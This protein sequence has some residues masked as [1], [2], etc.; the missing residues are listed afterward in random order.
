[1]GPFGR[2]LNENNIMF[3][4]LVR[5]L[6]LVV[7]R[8]GVME[9]LSKPSSNRFPMLVGY[10][11]VFYSSRTRKRQKKSSGYDSDEYESE[12]EMVE[13]DN[14]YDLYIDEDE[15]FNPDFRQMTSFVKSPRFDKILRVGLN[16]TRATADEAFLSSRLRLN[17][18]K[19]LKKSVLVQPGDKLDLVISDED[20]T[21]GKR[22][23]VIDVAEQKRDSY[24]VALRCWRSR[25]KL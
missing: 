5:H 10:L 8:L 24:R 17:G 7:N 9:P 1:M 14:E 2:E 20:G 3:G 19:L 22:V 13:S 6:Q 18:T 11:P 21:M 12:N 16:L 15:R 25:V 23:R 4:L